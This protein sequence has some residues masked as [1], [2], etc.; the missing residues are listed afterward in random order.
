MLLLPIQ[1]KIEVDIPISRLQVACIMVQDTHTD[2][3]KNALRPSQLHMGDSA[4]VMRDPALRDVEV[5]VADMH[6][7]MDIGYDDDTLAGCYC[8]NLGRGLVRGIAGYQNV[9]LK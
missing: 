9:S 7:S 1:C 8:G 5:W 2:S 6:L 4:I 3:D